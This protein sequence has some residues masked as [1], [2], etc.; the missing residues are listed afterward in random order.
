[1]ARRF[2]SNYLSEYF[3][4]LNTKTLS[5]SFW[6]GYLNC[7]NLKL[8]PQKFNENKNL[9][10]HLKDGI[11]SKINM[12]LPIKSF[13][14]GIN[15]DI[16]ITIEDIDI[17]L[18][19]NSDFEFFDYTNFDYKYSFIKSITDDLLFKMELSK[20]PNFNDT[21]LT[22]SINYF[23]RNMKIIVKNVRIKLIHGTSDLY[24]AVFCA[25]IDYINLKKD[26]FIIDK[27]YIYTENTINSNHN[28]RKKGHDYILLPIT[29]KSEISLLKK[30]ENE[31]N[32]KENINIE[33][34]TNNENNNNNN[35]N[36]K[37]IETY[38]VDFEIDEINFSINK[39]QFILIMNLINFF[40][41][42]GNFYNNCFIL[43]KIQYKKPKKE[44]NNIINNNNDNKEENIEKDKDKDKNYYY[45]LLR[46]YIK[47]LIL[48]FKEKKFNIDV[49]DY[50]KDV[51]TERKKIFQNK[52]NDFFFK[53]KK[54]DEMIDIIRF[55]DEDVL[56]KWIEEMCDSIYKYQKESAQGFFSGIK[57]YFF[58]NAF[59]G[60]EIS[61]LEEVSSRQKIICEFKGNINI[62]TLSLKNYNEEI[63][64]SI[65]ENEIE[66]FRGRIN[67]ILETRI[68]KIKL[69]FKHLINKSI[70]TKEIILPLV[71]DNENKE[72]YIK[73]IF[74]KF[75]PKTINE[76]SYLEVKCTSH[77]FIYNHSMFHSLYQFLYKDVTFMNKNFTHYKLFLRISSHKFDKENKVNLNIN[78]ANH[79]VIFPYLNY[80]YLNYY[81]D[82]KL[83]INFGDLDLKSS[84][85]YD[86]LV[87]NISVNFIDKNLITHPIIKNFNFILKSSFDLNTNNLQLK[88]IEIQASIYLLQTLLYK[89]RN[90]SESSKPE[91]IWK[92]KNKNK[93]H[94]YNNAIK[95]GYLYYINKDNDRLKYYALISGGYI[96][97]FKNN[98]NPKPEYLIPLYDSF[99]EEKYYNNK[100]F[101]FNIIFGGK[102][103]NGNQNDNKYEI[104]FNTKEE[105]EEWKNSIDYRIEE[106]NKTLINIKIKHKRKLSDP[107]QNNFNNSNINLNEEK[108]IDNKNNLKYGNDF[109]QLILEESKRIRNNII[110]K[111]EN[112]QQ[113]KLRMYLD[114]IMKFVNS[115]KGNRHFT[116]EI[117]N[118]S[119]ILNYSENESNMN[120]NYEKGCK[121]IL[122]KTK[123][124]YIE[125]NIFFIIQ[126]Y[127]GNIKFISNNINLIQVHDNLDE[128]LDINCFI[129]CNILICYD[130][131]YILL[132]K[133]RDKLLKLIPNIK[134]KEEIEDFILKVKTN[135]IKINIFKELDISFE[136]DEIF[137][138]IKL[139]KDFFKKIKRKFDE[140]IKIINKINININTEKN[141]S[142][143]HYDEINKSKYYLIIK[144]ICS[145]ENR[146]TLKDVHLMNIGN[147]NKNNKIIIREF[148]VIIKD[149]FNNQKIMYD[150][151]FSSD[152]CC[153]FDKNDFDNIYNIINDIR[154]TFR[155]N[156]YFN[157]KAKNGNNKINNF[158][159]LFRMKIKKIE[160]NFI[161]SSIFRTKNY[162]EI[163]LI[164]NN[165]LINK[166]KS[167][168]YI[169]I[170]EDIV[171]LRD[172][173]NGKNLLEN[174][175]NEKEIL[176][177]IPKSNN[178][179]YISYENIK[180]DKRKLLD[181][182]IDKI[183]LNFQYELL[184]DFLNFFI[185]IK[186]N[187]YH[188]QNK[189]N[190]ENISNNLET[191][192]NIP[193][194]SSFSNNTIISINNTM[195]NNL[196]INNEFKNLQPFRC[197]K[198][199]TPSNIC[200]N[201]LEFEPLQLFESLIINLN[202][203]SFL[204]KIPVKQQKNNIIIQNELNESIIGNN[205][206]ED[207]FEEIK[208]IQSEFFCIE[209]ISPLVKF[210][211]DLIESDRSLPYQRYLK[212]HSPETKIF[213]IN[214]E[215][216][217]D[218]KKIYSLSNNFSFFIELKY[219][220]E[221][222]KEMFIPQRKYNLY[223]YVPEELNI[224]LNFEQ[225][226]SLLNIIIDIKNY[227]QESKLT[228]FTYCYLAEPE[229]YTTMKTL[230]FEIC[231]HIQQKLV[232]RIEEFF[233]VIIKNLNLSYNDILPEKNNQ[234]IN[235]LFALIIKYYNQ[236]IKEYELFLEKYNF[237]FTARNN[238]FKFCS[239]DTSLIDCFNN[240][241]ENNNM[242]ENEF[243]KE[244]NNNNLSE[245]NDEINFNI[246]SENT[247]EKNNNPNGLSI[248]IT[249]ELLYI[250]NN[251]YDIFM[252]YKKC[253]VLQNIKNKNS[254]NSKNNNKSLLIYIYNYTTE[255]IQ[256][257]KINEIKQGEFMKYKINTK[258]DSLFDIKFIK[259]N[260]QYNE[261]KLNQ[262]QDII[263]YNKIYFCHDNTNKYYFLYPIMCKSFC[264]KEIIISNFSN[265][266]SI[267]LNSNKIQGLDINSFKNKTILFKINDNMIV[268]L[269][270]HLIEKIKNYLTNNNDENH[271]IIVKDYFILK[272]EF[273]YNNK[274]V[275]KI[276]IFP[277][278]IIL[279]TLNIPIIFYGILNKYQDVNK[280]MIETEL[281][282]DGKTTDIFYPDL[283]QLTFKLKIIDNEVKNGN[284]EFISEISSINND[285][286]D[287]SFENFENNHLNEINTHINI[288]GN[289]LFNNNNLGYIENKKIK[290]INGKIKV[291]FKISEDLII[292]IIYH[293]IPETRQIKIYLYMDYFILNNT[294]LNIYPLN[295]CISFNDKN[296]M[297]NYYPLKNFKNFQLVVA[298]KI[299]DKF[300]IRKEDYAFFTHIEVE[301]VKDKKINLLIQ[302]HLRYFKLG[303]KL[304][305][306]D[307]LIISQIQKSN[308]DNKNNINNIVV[309]SNTI[310]KMKQFSNE[311]NNDKDNNNIYNDDD[312]L[313]KLVKQRNFIDMPE[314]NDINHKF[315]FQFNLPSVYVIVI[316]NNKNDNINNKNEFEFGC[317]Y[318]IVSLYL[319][320]IDF[321]FTQEKINFKKENGKVIEDDTISNININN[322]K[323]NFNKNNR[324][325]C[326]F[327][328]NNNS[329]DI[330]D[331]IEDTYNNN[332]ELTI[333]SIQ[334]DNLLQNV[335]YKIIFYNKKVYK[336]LLSPFN[337]NSYNYKNNY[338]TWLGM[339]F[340]SE[341]NKSNNLNEESNNNNMSNNKLLPFIHF[342]G[343]FINQDYKYYFKEIN[344][345]FLPCYLYLDSEF[346]SEL[347][348]FISES[349]NIFK[350]KN[351]YYSQSIKE[352]IESLSFNLDSNFSSKFFMFISSF[353]VSPL[354]I[355]FN[356]KNFS[357]R[358]FNLL[359]LQSN[360]INTLL[361]VFTN[362][363][364]SIK[365]QFNSIVLYDINVRFNALLYKLYDYYY[366]TF[367]RECIKIIFSVDILGD[368]YHLLSHLSQGISN[369]ITLPILS[370]FNGPSDFIF[371][372][373][374]GTKSLLSNSIGGLLDS[375]HKFTNSISK[376]ILKLTNSEEYLKSRNKI[377]I[378]ENYLDEN[379]INYLENNKRKRNYNNNSN[380]FNL[381]LISKIL[382]NG[383]KYGFRDLIVIPYKYYQNNGMIELPIGVILGTLSLIVKP[384]SS[385]M[386]SISILSNSISHEILKGEKNYDIDEDYMYYSYNKKR[387]RREWI[388]DDKK[389]RR[390]KEENIDILLKLIGDCFNIDNEIERGIING[391][392]YIDKLFITKYKIKIDESNSNEILFNNDN[393]INEMKNIKENKD[394]IN[395]N[396]IL[397]FTVI[398]FIKNIKNNEF[399]I[400]IYIININRNKNER[401]FEL[402]KN[403]NKSDKD[404][405]I[406]MNL[407]YIIPCKDIISL[408]YNKND[409]NIN[410][411]YQKERK[412]EKIN[413]T[414]IIHL[415]KFNNF[416]A[417]Y[418]FL[419]FNKEKAYININFSS[420]YI[421]NEFLDYY[422]KIKYNVIKPN[423]K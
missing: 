361:D 392:Y 105:M 334:I 226:K 142:L 310:N 406:S 231:G 298:D 108:E 139:I 374:Y 217:N 276:E 283:P 25:N 22:R 359:N 286:I 409:K 33:N 259:S 373:L 156:F 390:Y 353:K 132:D 120:I 154:Y 327:D 289:N 211:I 378:K 83:E 312:I 137:M 352:I 316:A 290:M 277:R 84:E 76:K 329:N 4:N 278:Y 384:I 342:K 212:I 194:N 408:N 400:M 172:I 393:E 138:N 351:L 338:L 421:L 155:N 266:D 377:L 114:Q 1:M 220:Y 58:N 16:E 150:I 369:F 296:F 66:F 110:N 269:N 367:L 354:T 240:E 27:F 97:L 118:I 96:Y 422:S 179:I 221:I 337:D 192:S 242:D 44:N 51:N 410:I 348:L 414:K 318:E 93:N 121:I 237:K 130:S 309:N 209:F 117:E 239:D 169:Y 379:L 98:E 163:K 73:Y 82:E 176:L 381:L 376:N 100:I 42:Y 268:S 275:I 133:N 234:E 287:D 253:H 38:Y 272:F 325:N 398:T 201:N 345:C 236:N 397:S 317:R 191:S 420:K 189:N 103:S 362:N 404:Y 166:E 81:N 165:I 75:I 206:D 196:N 366:Y 2:I 304:Y 171:L 396:F 79:K 281:N 40:I 32:N 70:F 399:S 227:Y 140:S 49:F 74:K 307:F 112:N 264:Q 256:I 101:G 314:V 68:G 136:S 153:Y 10:I 183:I 382:G 215:I 29:M 141:I 48:I 244:K 251:I 254:L 106:I 368:P 299:L 26:S 292:K 225:L 370:I 273:I 282:I 412:R 328:L 386:D 11:I 5:L 344:I 127:F 31:I 357:N 178:A 391:N 330:L 261:I 184:Y 123:I 52:F 157:N 358:F 53:N 50:Y 335:I 297:V 144:K 198:E 152:I 365:F 347:F 332:I 311:L 167:N 205:L 199:N 7:E 416:G 383:I 346:S 233:E 274:N 331:D 159:R 107:N 229:I 285:Y 89:T 210:D 249:I 302:R 308:I 339:P 324:I 413:N 372:L 111:F 170:V 18:I 321:N 135:Q 99:L 119:L 34:N 35:N 88:N 265:N 402:F 6:S 280:K 222:H 207:E 394:Q 349:Y 216:N 193:I 65:L 85:Q 87:E 300:E 149:S 403:K 63:K 62:I 162:N 407:Q 92:I 313:M 288:S 180:K 385:T 69:S 419:Y 23:L 45:S 343:S 78:I 232:I 148:D 252:L 375:L 125:N 187:S 230:F 356:Y 255:T 160:I 223:F 173:K 245:S 263:I 188:Y 326:D 295:N 41:D 341:K 243:R 200:D 86:I 323:N 131:S 116:F 146:T 134:K 411:L 77:V 109:S 405:K 8:N 247:F 319:D 271:K 158:L 46:H 128:N 15:N 145:K 104:N 60:M 350:N 208:K 380:G 151:E 37:E 315:S 401:K 320:N 122:N 202:I 39:E 364:T 126:S 284:N 218:N 17:N 94:I 355:F 36:T 336:K 250:I 294:K 301:I 363:T 91:N 168:N 147:E 20:N 333:Q 30:N 71:N 59:E 238:Y 67:K 224:N 415:L 257:N 293:T 28:I 303:E 19:T 219:N 47:G 248:N 418:R 360:F 175:E 262:L 190:K 389:I 43:R 72:I 197:R 113:K 14:L 291:K 80:D 61:N 417:F 174:M 204:L 56:K 267:L 57:S 3:L 395:N 161:I 260:I 388:Y 64:L 258:K 214:E 115:S 387:Q 270:D 55:T 241:E 195:N 124:E 306:I 235:I 21:Y 129:N 90:I 305:K 164:L 203:N 340:L 9:P 12:S 371:Y 24:N 185:N 228:Y 54:D 322:I 246:K 102:N 213:I 182:V 13:F 95:K 423:M 186:Y 143:I 279:N 177:K 181:L